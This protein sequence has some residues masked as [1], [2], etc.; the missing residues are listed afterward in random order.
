MPIL[1]DAEHN[2]QVE[3]SEGDV[4]PLTLGLPQ[5]DGRVIPAMV[6]LPMHEAMTLNDP[7]QKNRKFTDFDVR[8]IFTNTNQVD[9]MMMQLE[10]ARRILSIGQEDEEELT[11][12]EITEEAGEY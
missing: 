3:F 2:I 1:R 8:M 6:I 5:E 7:E 11:E 9:F 4:I 12:D 10:E